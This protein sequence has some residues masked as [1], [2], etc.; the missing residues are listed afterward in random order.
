[1]LSDYFDIHSHINF[2]EF[3]ADREVVLSRLADSRTAT[4]TVGTELISSQSAVALAETNPNVYAC[5]GV[6][7]VDNPARAFEITEFEKLVTHPKVVAIG[8]CGLDYFRLEGESV[9]EK[10]RQKELF[11][12]QIEFALRHKKALMI[13]SRSAYEDTLVILEEYKKEYGDT[14]WGN[15]HFFAGDIKIADSFLALNFSLSFTG[16]I[17]FTHDYDEVIKSAPLSMIMSET[18]S[19]YVAPVPYRGKR[20]EPSYVNEVVKKIAEIRGEDFEMVKTAMRENALRR[21]TIPT[22]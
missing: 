8:E 10:K 17:T 19:P 15:V 6:H 12:S 4:I 16:V 9:E 5:I 18:D 21:F 1:M 3:D 13:H 11:R 20:N 14:L 2:P 22:L 7:P